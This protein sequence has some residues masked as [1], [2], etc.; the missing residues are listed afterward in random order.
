MKS[1]KKV[2]LV[3]ILIA[4]VIFTATSLYIAFYKARYDIAQ[5]RTV[6]VVFGAG[7]TKSG[8]PSLALK[9]RLDKS[10]ELYHHNK[11]KLIFVSGKIAETF[12]MK[13]YLIKNGIT[14]QAVITDYNGKNTLFTIE[15]AQRFSKSNHIQDGLV[16]ISQ[17]Y[18]IPRIAMMAN[19]KKIKDPYFIAADPKK[20]DRDDQITFI[21]RESLAFLKSLFLDN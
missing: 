12:V 16:F 2:L 19:K 18:H 10:M 21:L 13:N 8:E 11:I 6:G 15:N 3:L 1:F 4:A 7:I 17:K 14:N 20:I 5:G 9:Y